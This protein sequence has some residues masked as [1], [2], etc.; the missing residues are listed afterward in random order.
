MCL[1]CVHT[2]QTLKK[3]VHIFP[4]SVAPECGVGYVLMQEV[5]RILP[6]SNAS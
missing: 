6:E 3:Q 4:I 2:T 1:L 5:N